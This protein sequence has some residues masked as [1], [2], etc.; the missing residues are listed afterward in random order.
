MKISRKKHSI[1]KTKSVLKNRWFWTVLLLCLLTAGLT[2]TFLFSEFFQVK[3]IRIYGAE[4]ISSSSAQDLL[5]PKISAR[6]LGIESKS[7]F[8]V[9]TKA[10]QAALKEK[11]PEIDTLK[12]KRVF[13]QVLQAEISE[14][15]SVALWCWDNNCFFVDTKGVIFEP[16][17]K[18]FALVINSKE[19]VFEISPGKKVIEEDM[20]KQ[21]SMIQKTMKDSAKIEARE[22]TFFEKEKRLNAKTSEGWEVYFDL[23]GNTNWQLVRLGLLLQ[24]D[25]PQEKRQGLEYVDLRFSKV[26]YK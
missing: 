21:I 8:L 9:D 22:F 3:E 24:K 13:P 5:W 16:G 10:L 20:L 12:I 15:K 7:I 23:A 6:I 25:L 4:K 1:K 2:Y 18:P 11:F 14:R 17:A 26:Y 19:A